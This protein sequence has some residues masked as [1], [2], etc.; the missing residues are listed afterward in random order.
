L[1]IVNFYVGAL[2]IPQDDPGRQKLETAFGNKAEIGVL[3]QDWTRVQGRDILMATANNPGMTGNAAGIGLGLGM[4]MAAGSAASTM[5]ATVFS[6][7]ATAGSAT[8]RLECPSC[9]K[10]SPAGT[11]FCGECGTQLAVEK[12]FCTSCGKELTRGA[13]FCGECGAKQGG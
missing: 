8:G 7:P 11:K 5:A 6:P 10:K 13:K 4:G 1:E 9:H 3:N 12:A 2:D